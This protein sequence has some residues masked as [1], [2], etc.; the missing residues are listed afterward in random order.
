MDESVDRARQRG[1]PFKVMTMYLKTC[2]GYKAD[3]LLTA[4]RIPS[5]I[6]PWPAWPATLASSKIPE[7]VVVEILECIYNH[8]L[9]SE[10]YDT[11]LACS[12]ICKAWTSPAQRVPFRAVA[13]ERNKTKRRHPFIRALTRKP[14][15]GKYVRSIHHLHVIPDT[16]RKAHSLNGNAVTEPQLAF[17]LTLCPQ[18]CELCINFDKSTVDMQALLSR[19]GRGIK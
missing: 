11:I 1:A 7:D 14:H 16:L 5:V 18:L 8:H 19:T 3:R 12:L 9:D 10:H 4:S 2:A 15:P 6:K 13:T 17:I